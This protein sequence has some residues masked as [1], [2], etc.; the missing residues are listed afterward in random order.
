MVKR[1]TFFRY[2]PICP[3]F[4]GFSKKTENQPPVLEDTPDNIE[5]G[6]VCTKV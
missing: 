6:S 4:R 5:T 3:V 1:T 2:V